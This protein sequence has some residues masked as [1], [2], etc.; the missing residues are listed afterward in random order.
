M[1]KVENFEAINQFKLSDDE[2]FVFQSYDSFILEVNRSSR[3]ITKIG[4]NWDYSR[5]T[6]KYCKHFI[7]AYCYTDKYLS[8]SHFEKF[9][10]EN[11]YYDD[12][13]IVYVRKE[14]EVK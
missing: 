8:K 3:K 14:E 1:L 10:Q 11:F 9:I 7:E 5:T 2:N 13:N 12:V 6:M 4:I